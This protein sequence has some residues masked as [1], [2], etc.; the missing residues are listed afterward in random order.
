[1][2]CY[3]D[4]VKPT[5]SYYEDY[6]FPTPRTIPDKEENDCELNM[7][8]IVFEQLFDNMLN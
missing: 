7:F 5:R 6:V 8:D 2:R 4:Y 3:E 1:M